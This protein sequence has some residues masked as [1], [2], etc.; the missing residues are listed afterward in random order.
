MNKTGGTGKNRL[1]LAIRNNLVGYSFIL[2]NFTGFFV[3]ILIPISFSLVLSFMQWDGFNVM[4]FNGIKNFTSIL[5]ESIFRQSVNRTFIYTIS[6]VVFTAS[7]SLGLAVLL[8]RKFKGRGFFRSA[9]FF[10]Y[11][12]SIV[13]IAVVWRLL[14][15]RDAGPI[16]VFL[17]LIGLTDP[18][19]W[20][21]STQWALPAVIIVAIWRSM[22]YY[23]IVYLAALQ[24]IPK[25]LHEA[26]S[27]DGA[28]GFKYFWK[29]VFP[30]LTPATFFVVLMLTIN[31][32]KSFDIIFALTE[33]G[34]G[35]ATT[36]IS[37]YIYNKAF[38]AFNYGQTSAAAMI[39]F[40]IVALLTFFQ[41]KL[42]KK[43]S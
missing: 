30:L 17:R 31:S 41:F 37:N 38:I 13:S 11:V 2:P 35:T 7:A 36:L 23:M 16:N 24:N 42:E 26:A 10:P 39:L 22:G 21:A 34:P 4:S 6:C 32:F 8:N 9:V 18:P 3:F 29:I 14:F 43:I 12:A 20:F 28:S 27:M 5:N 25:E 33:G 19:G 40:I 1:S 15:M